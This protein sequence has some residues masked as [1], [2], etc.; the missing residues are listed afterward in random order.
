MS[1]LKPALKPYNL[2]TALFDDCG[3]DCI[4]IDVSGGRYGP[5][6]PSLSSVVKQVDGYLRQVD[7]PAFAAKK[8]YVTGQWITTPL[9]ESFV[10]ETG[11]VEIKVS[12][13]IALA[14]LVM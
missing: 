10:G 13:S 7:V 3:E 9:E 11:A 1:E 4:V 6:T 8:F 5:F 14:R 2:E 12:P